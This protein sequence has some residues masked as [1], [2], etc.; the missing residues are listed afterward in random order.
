M[1]DPEKL[2]V[3][4]NVTY[5]IQ[6]TVTEVCSKT[7]DGSDVEEARIGLPVGFVPTKV[8]DSINKRKKNDFSKFKEMKFLTFPTHP[9]HNQGSII[10]RKFMIVANYRLYEKMVPC[11]SSLAAFLK[12]KTLMI[13][14]L[15]S[16][17]IRR[18]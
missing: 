1:I 3:G 8:R 18:E 13:T 5:W 10:I 11:V 7:F 12:G 2:S 15:Q 4:I 9:R 17:S 14:S 6:G 16:L